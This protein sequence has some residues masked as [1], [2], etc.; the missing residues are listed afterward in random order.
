MYESKPDLPFMTYDAVK[1]SM[2]CRLVLPTHFLQPA[3]LGPK[4][5]TRSTVCFESDLELV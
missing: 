3:I 1:H 5:N 2:R 4:N